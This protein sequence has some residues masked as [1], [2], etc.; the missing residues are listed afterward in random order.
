MV[1]TMDEFIVIKV[2]NEATKRLLES[3]HEDS[4]KNQ[5]INEY[6]KDEAFFYK[7]SKESA[8]KILLAVGVKSEQL[9]NTY[10]KLISPSVYYRLVRE[11]KIDINDKSLVIKYS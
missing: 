3:K 9:E 4:I 1:L 6:L 7:I 8:F 11:G 5:K 10:K 2:M